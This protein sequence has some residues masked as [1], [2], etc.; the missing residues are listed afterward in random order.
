M[1]SEPVRGPRPPFPTQIERFDFYE[2]IQVQ[3]DFA[4]GR[5]PAPSD[6]EQNPGFFRP[7]E[8]VANIRGYLV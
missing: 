5:V 4:A 8:E 2:I 1:A 7:P 6:T 3:K